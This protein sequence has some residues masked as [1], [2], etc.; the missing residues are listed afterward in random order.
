[1][2]KSTAVL[3][4]VLLVIV[5]FL[6]IRY[7]RKKREVMLKVEVPVLLGIDDFMD[8]MPLWD[9]GSVYRKQEF[10]LGYAE[11]FEQAAWV[12]YLLTADHVRNANLERQ[13]R[14]L[15]DP[16]IITGSAVHSDYTRSGYDRGHLVPAKDM[17]WSETGSLESFLCSNIS[18]Q[19]PGF[20]RGVW[21]NLEEAVREWALRNDS[22][23]VI[24]GPVLNDVSKFI[25]KN[26]VGVPRAF[27]KIVVDISWPEY[28]AVAFLME[29]RETEAGF[30]EYAVSIDSVESVTG[31]DFM[32]RV[33]GPLI[34][35]LEADIPER[36][37]WVE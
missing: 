31:L 22:L 7:Q 32:H 20:N 13:D 2:K 1:M 24:T 12:C 37:L 30:A 4:I 33:T 27:Y 19:A 9:S 28:K 21:K 6:I 10:V 16:E 26:E 3:M 11:E 35:S 5:V 34:K 14:F 25:G 15:A 23:L 8:G 36:G 17:A 18:P 29:N